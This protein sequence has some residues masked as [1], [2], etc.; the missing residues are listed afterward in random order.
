M[1][2]Q[3]RQNISIVI[4]MGILMIPILLRDCLYKVVVCYFR[5]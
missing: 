1:T 3:S 2:T 5:E 4:F